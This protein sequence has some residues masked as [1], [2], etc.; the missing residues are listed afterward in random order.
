MN[1]ALSA[2]PGPVLIVAMMSH[3]S[4]PTKNQFRPRGDRSSALNDASPHYFL[5]TESDPRQRGALL[6][7]AD[8]QNRM[9]PRDTSQFAGSLLQFRVVGDCD[10][11]G[12]LDSPSPEAEFQETVNQEQSH[13]QSRGAGGDVCK[14]HLKSDYEA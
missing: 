11:D 2:R 3:A 1:L 9:K 8:L 6:S 5:R 13:A 4:S 12:G 10:N 7:D 14:N